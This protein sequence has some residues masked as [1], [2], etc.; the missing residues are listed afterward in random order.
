MHRQRRVVHREKSGGSERAHDMKVTTLGQAATHARPSK[1]VRRVGIFCAPATIRNMP[2]F[3]P[4]LHSL[5]PCLSPKNTIFC[6]LARI[7]QA[8]SALYP[9]ISCNA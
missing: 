2:E 7:Y 8:V 9:N 3:L 5:V 6:D 4:R 1:E